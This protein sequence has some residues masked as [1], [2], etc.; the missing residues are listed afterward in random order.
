MFLRACSTPE[1][2]NHE[3]WAAQ[4]SQPKWMDKLQEIYWNSWLFVPSEA[5]ELTLKNIGIRLGN[6][7]GLHE[8]LVETATVH[9]EFRRK[10]ES[11]ALKEGSDQREEIAG[12]V[13]LVI[14]GYQDLQEYAQSS[15]E[16]VREMRR[17]VFDMILSQSQAQAEEFIDGYRIGAAKAREVDLVESIC[18]RDERKQICRIL[19]D[20]WPQI[21]EM[22]NRT[23]ITNYVCSR[24]PKARRAFLHE[25]T[26]RRAFDGRMREI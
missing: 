23:E 17:A 25:E 4:A 10:W 20:N 19:S 9:E 6:Q 3:W 24:L 13:V 22:P 2:Y 5:E 26:N 14:N 18:D 1:G 8:R 16:S 15:F 12:K 21:E 11:A 7:L